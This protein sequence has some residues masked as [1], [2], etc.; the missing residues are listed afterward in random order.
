MVDKGRHQKKE[1]AD[2]LSRLDS[3]LF[4]VE[5]IHRGH[6]WGRVVC[7]ACGEDFA[8]W[9]TP[10]RPH[11]EARRIDSFATHHAALHMMNGGH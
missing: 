3:S 8:V 2:A 1:I 7:L 4:M 5:P 6:R 9:S 10:A 11:D